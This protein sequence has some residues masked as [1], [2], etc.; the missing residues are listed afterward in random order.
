MLTS[1]AAGRKGPDAARAAILK[2]ARRLYVAHGASGISARKI[3]REVGCSPTAIYLYFRNIADIL[4]HLR[5]EGHALL[6][7]G[8]KR[9][10]AGL[11]AL[12]RVRAM[13]RAYWRF[14]LD[15]R[16]Y[17]ALMFTL[18]AAETPGREAVQREMSTL[19]LLRDAVVRGIETGRSAA[20][21]IRPSSPT[22]CGRRSTGW[23]RWRCRGCWY[24]RRP[25][26]ARRYWRRCWRAPR[27]GCREV[28]SVN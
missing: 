14:A 7:A 24:R 13:G 25:G 18:R 2:A 15:H 3:A 11:P 1:A 26:S 27:A 6:A 28:N 23:R 5:M 19:F 10:D 16:G 22:C 4:E 17:Y 12:E 20:T 21:S 9:V 8:L